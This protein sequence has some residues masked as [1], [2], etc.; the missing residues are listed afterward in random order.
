MTPLFTCFYIKK[1]DS[2]KK[3]SSIG[4]EN[5]MEDYTRKES[6][7]SSRQSSMLVST[8]S[9]D[10]EFQNATKQ[11]SVEAMNNSEASSP[12]SSASALMRKSRLKRGPTLHHNQGTAK[13]QKKTIFALT[14]Y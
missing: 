6:I 1:V 14:K 10:H 4:D 2:P 8:S 7:N 3:K 13:I 9:K 5:G 11:P 12:V